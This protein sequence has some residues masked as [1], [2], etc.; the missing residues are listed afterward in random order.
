[1]GVHRARPHRNRL[2]ADPFDG[3]D[4]IFFLADSVCRLLLPPL[5]LH[6]FLMF[7]VR[8]RSRWLRR[9]APW[10]YLPAT[11]LLV[12][13]FDQ[14]FGNGT[15]TGGLSATTLERQDRIELALLV[16]F[17]LAAAA[18]LGRSLL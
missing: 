7:P 8:P 17:A 13:Q 9:A 15:L 12:V 2:P 14:I 11:A 4:R 10:L 3:I 6:F 1:M 5:T 18:M 16:V